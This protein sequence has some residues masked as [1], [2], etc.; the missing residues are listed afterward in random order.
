MSRTVSGSPAV[1]IV[2]AAASSAAPV[3]VSGGGLSYELVHER[4]LDERG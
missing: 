1:V 4:G 2:S 3:A